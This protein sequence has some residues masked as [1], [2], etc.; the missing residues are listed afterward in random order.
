MVRTTS[1]RRNKMTLLFREDNRKV[2]RHHVEEIKESIKAHG[3]LN[4]APIVLN[5]QG[6]IIDG[7]HRYIA[8]CELGITPPTITLTGDN[9][10]LMVD[11]NR[12][13]KAWGID[14][15][16]NFYSKMGKMSFQVLQE[17]CKKTKLAVTPALMILTGKFSNFDVIRKGDLVFDCDNKLLVKKYEIADD[18]SRIARLL[19]L[20]RGN[21]SITDAYLSL[22]G[23]DGFNREYFIQKMYRYR[24]RL[25]L[26][27]SAKSYL[28]MF[29]AVYNY[30][31]KGGE[32]VL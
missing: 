21:K 12:S 11:L 32:I 19:K 15:F 28:Q 23:I 22:I 16:V 4:H 31:N 10:Q 18:V 3:Y 2:V 17:F 14:D 24:D 26:C 8:C 7:Q 13:Q 20:H 25:A 9:S 6:E 1:E 5:E 27:A 30:R 29:V